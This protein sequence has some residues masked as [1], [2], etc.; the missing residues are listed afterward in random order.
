[1]VTT[2]ASPSPTQKPTPGRMIL[3]IM[4]SPNLLLAVGTFL[5]GFL[6][7]VLA[8]YLGDLTIFSFP[9]NQ[10]ILIVGTA[11]LLI[12][13]FAYRRWI[14]NLAPK[15]IG[16]VEGMAG[17]IV[18][19]STLNARAFGT[20]QQR[21]QRKELVKKAVERIG[22]ATAVDAVPPEFYEALFGTN[23]EPALEALQFHFR[24]GTLRDC[25]P[26]GTED[27]SMN[28]KVITPGST[29]LAK[30]LQYWFT[31]L[32]PEHHVDFHEV[33]PVPARDYIRL[34][35]AVD[36]VYRKSPFR[37]RSIICDVTG[38]LKLMS[39]GAALA[40]ISPRRQMQYMATARDSEGIPDGTM[41]P[42][43]VKISSYGNPDELE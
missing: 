1:M 4:G 28:G 35:A 40:C 16:P 8:G 2:Q 38:G 11:G 25:W 43:L 19:L 33:A 7:D 31:Y 36:D 39:V 12:L 22:E 10:V 9:A 3:D 23:L 29:Y 21:Q 32:H 26:I 13:F 18:L 20:A 42:V 27:E 17:V 15:E 41:V 24:K 34:H 14:T 30:V 5:L 6:S 37:E